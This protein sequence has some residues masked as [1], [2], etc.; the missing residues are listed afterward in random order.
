M[1]K[2]ANC[3]IILLNHSSAV[4]RRQQ[5]AAESCLFIRQQFA[6]GSKLL[7][8][9]AYSF[10][11]SLQKAANCCRILLNHS[12]AVCRRQQTAAFFSGISCAMHQ[13]GF[14][15]YFKCGDHI[16]FTICLPKVNQRKYMRWYVF[17]LIVHVQLYT[18]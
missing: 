15:S 7:Q 3:C 14:P 6:E 12:A 4:C 10:G 16:L 11:S 17:N 5:T 13:Q 18:N 9:L 8:K 1:Q 2:A